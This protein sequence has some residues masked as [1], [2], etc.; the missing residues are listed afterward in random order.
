[1]TGGRGSR[2]LWLRQGQKVRHTMI[3]FMNILLIQEAGVRE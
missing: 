2:K 1:M 3:V